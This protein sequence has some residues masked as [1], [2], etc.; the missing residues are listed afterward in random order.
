VT[1]VDRLPDH[2]NHEVWRQ[3]MGRNTF[4]LETTVCQPPVRLVRTIADDHQMLSGDWE[5]EVLPDENGTRVQVTE[6]GRGKG[7]GPG[8][9]MLVHALGALFFAV[10]FAV[11]ADKMG[12]QMPGG[13]WAGL[14]FGVLVW[15]AARWPRAMGFGLF[16]NVHR[17]FVVGVLLA[18]L[19]ACLV[20]GGVC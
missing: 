13:V 8:G 7:H 4:V 14:L 5:Y 20:C 10:R 16:A 2:D 3:H 12:G 18:D 9:A 6:H 19:C 15:A 17:G 11:V 1:K